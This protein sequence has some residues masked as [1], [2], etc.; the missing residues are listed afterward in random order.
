MNPFGR[1]YSINDA[2]E[3]GGKKRSFWYVWTW[4]ECRTYNLIVNSRT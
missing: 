2:E 4:P 3:D 1:K